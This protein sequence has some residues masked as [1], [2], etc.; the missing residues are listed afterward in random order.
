M[1]SQI[2]RNLSEQRQLIG[3]RE[4]LISIIEKGNNEL[5]KLEVEIKNFCKLHPEYNNNDHLLVTFSLILI[6][7]IY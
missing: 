4:E 2:D 3:E 1:E 6:Y 5:K 7:I